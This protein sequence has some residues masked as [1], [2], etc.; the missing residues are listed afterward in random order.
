M[1]RMW[2]GKAIGAVVG[3]AFSDASL[4]LQVGGKLSRQELDNRLMK[5][6]VR[7]GQ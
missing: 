2:F 4:D 1:T 3:N 6:K 5:M 7:T